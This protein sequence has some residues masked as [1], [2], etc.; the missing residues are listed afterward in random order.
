[1]T[2]IP[3]ASKDPS[4]KGVAGGE[5]E[6]FIAAA[7]GVLN[8]PEHREKM[9][10]LKRQDQ[11]DAQQRLRDIARQNRQR[12]FRELATRRDSERILPMA[13][14]TPENWPGPC[15]ENLPG[16]TFHNYVIR[17]Q[18]LLVSD[19]NDFDYVDDARPASD[20]EGNRGVRW[21]AGFLL[22][23]ANTLAS[24]HDPDYI[25]PTLRLSLV[26]ML[27]DATDI[28]DKQLSK[29]ESPSEYLAGRQLVAD[30]IVVATEAFNTA[31]FEIE[32]GLS[33]L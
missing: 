22:M 20:V 27:S 9:Q 7:Y 25:R 14:A 21:Q 6:S 28:A 13:E 1:M 11:A 15:S 5:P 12:F 23:Q 24:T 16:A 3:P 10:A 2:E 33:D 31:A 26:E 19:K 4:A 8:T 18:E 30:A 29:V 32:A 17:A